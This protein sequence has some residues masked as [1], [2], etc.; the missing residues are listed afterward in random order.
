MG[1]PPLLLPIHRLAGDVEARLDGFRRRDQ[2]HDLGDPGLVVALLFRDERD[3]HRHIWA[4]AKANDGA[5]VCC[6]GGEVSKPGGRLPRMGKA[7][8]QLS[9]NGV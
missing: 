7:G 6:F 4:L 9:L 1:R 5:L 8:A 2:A 3:Q